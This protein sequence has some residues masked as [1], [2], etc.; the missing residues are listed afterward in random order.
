MNINELTKFNNNPNLEI[1]DEEDEN[2]EIEEKPKIENNRV[3][4]I[5]CD[6]PSLPTPVE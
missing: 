4:C 3:K 1:I 2:E 6:Y 5:I